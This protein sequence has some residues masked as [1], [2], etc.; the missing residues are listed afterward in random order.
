MAAGW[1]NVSDFYKIHIFCR[2]SKIMGPVYFYFA[3]RPIGIEKKNRESSKFVKYRY[4]YRRY[5]GNG[6]TYN[7]KLYITE[8]LLKRRT[9]RHP[10]RQDTTR[11]VG[12]IPS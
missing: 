1:K 5:L 11:I 4:F 8:K 10:T 3:I 12:N 7:I 6:G 2:G 9:Q